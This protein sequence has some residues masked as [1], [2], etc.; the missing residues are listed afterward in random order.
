MS[1]HDMRP[2]VKLPYGFKLPSQFLRLREL[3][4]M[5]LEP[6]DVLTDDRMLNVAKRLA[7]MYP[8][9]ALV[10]FARR[11]DNDDIACWDGGDSTKVH[12]IHIFTSPG[13][14]QREVFLTFY[15]WFR[16]AVEDFI[17]FDS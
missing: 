7:D 4:L 12:I 17:D 3:D 1:T 2:T 9:R 8:A 5:K 6:W 16:A 10:P 14:E 15:D 11:Q 13:H